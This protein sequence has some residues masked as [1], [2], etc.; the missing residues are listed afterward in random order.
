LDEAKKA[1]GLKN[2]LPLRSFFKAF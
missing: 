2:K 1:L